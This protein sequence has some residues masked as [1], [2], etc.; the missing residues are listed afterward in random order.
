MNILQILPELNLGGVETGVLDLSKELVKLGHKV[1][2]VSNGGDL[3]NKLIWFGAI[4]YTLPVHQKNIFTMIKSYFK[5]VQIIKK[6]NIQIIHARSRVPAWIAYFASRRTKTVFITTCHGYYKRSIFSYIMGWGKKVIVISRAIRKYM[7]EDFAVPPERIVLIPRAVDLEKFKFIDP[8]EKRKR[9]NFNV[10]IIGRITPLKGH[11][12]FIQA[13]AE[14][15]RFIPNLKILIVGEAPSSKQDYKEKIKNLIKRLGLE[16]EVIFLGVTQDIPSVFLE[17]DCLVLAT[18]THE[19]FGR[20]TIE[21]GASGV[22]VVATRVGGVVDIIEDKK[23]GILVTPADSHEIAS[24]VIE[25]YQNPGLAKNLAYA[26]YEKVK[27]EYNLDLFVK[28][29]LQV[30]QE[31]LETKKILLVKISALGDV[32]LST[33]SIKAIKKKNPTYRLS[34]LIGRREK[35]ILLNSPYIDEL[36]VVD[37]KG[38]DRSSFGLFKL[39]KILKRKD[40]DILI[41]LQNNLRSHLLGFLSGIRERYGFNRKFG[42]MLTKRIPYDKMD[43][44]PLEHQERILKLLGIELGNET[45]ELWPSKEDCNY[46]EGFL[47]SFWLTPNK[48]LIGINIEASQ[49]W[50]TKTWPKEYIFKLCQRLIQKKFTPILTGTE[51]EYNFVLDLEKNIPGIINACGKTTI[52][53]LVCLIKHCSVFVSSDSAPLHIAV[54]VKTPYIALFGPTDPKKHLVENERG[55][56][57]YHRLA[58]SPCYKKRCKNKDCMYAITPDEVLSA[59][60]RILNETPQ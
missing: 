42:F 56:L 50:Q 2:V 12:Y 6:E 54:A 18:T 20:V 35:D 24:A 17:L 19:G 22:P 1:V 32:I 38:K 27:K 41:D 53:Q 55:I 3:V 14:A 40:F 28:R 10:G 31:A 48:K 46:V 26:N 11:L 45:L 57:L 13:M 49:K 44:G 16:K 4:H 60:E 43:K 15:K 51:K 23:N 29:N 47:S 37:F 9:I 36:I 8:L 25:I 52:N 39:A 58:C 21:A 33:A 7:I 59:I 34:V 30:Y 5:L